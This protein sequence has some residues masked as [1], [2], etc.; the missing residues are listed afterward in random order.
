MERAPARARELGVGAVGGDVAGDE[1]AAAEELG[2]EQYPPREYHDQQRD[3]RAAGRTR[4]GRGGRG[5]RA[6]RGGPGRALPARAVV[7]PGSMP[8]AF[9]AGSYGVPCA[10][11][12]GARSASTD[13]KTSLNQALREHGVP[14]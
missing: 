4:A 12:V 13:L 10:L 5:G 1:E 14:V 2:R 9:P 6:G 7:I 3:A 8:K 11:I